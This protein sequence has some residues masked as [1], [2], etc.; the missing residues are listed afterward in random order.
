MNTFYIFFNIK[1][2]KVRL[3]FIGVVDMNEFKRIDKIFSLD[4]KYRKS[5]FIFPC[6]N[7]IRNINL[8]I[9]EKYDG[10]PIGLING[11]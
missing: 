9:C 6:E 8:N 5:T 11:E 2:I 1:D 4:N 10:K 7:C 3:L